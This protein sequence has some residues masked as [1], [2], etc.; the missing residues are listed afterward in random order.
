MLR[1]QTQREKRA[2]IRPRQPMMVA[3]T[4]TSRTGSYCALGIEEAMTLILDGRTG[5]STSP[6]H[7]LY[8]HPAR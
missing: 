8:A 5:S 4:P 7:T 3:D 2:S 1:V 6:E